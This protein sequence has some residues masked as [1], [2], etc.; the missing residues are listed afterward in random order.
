MK[1]NE[2]KPPADLNKKTQEDNIKPFIKEQ[3]NTYLDFCEDLDEFIQKTGESYN[4]QGL[5][6]KNFFYDL[7][8]VWKTNILE[9]YVWTNKAYE[10]KLKQIFGDTSPEPGLF[11]PAKDSEETIESYLKQRANRNIDEVEQRDVP[12]RQKKRIISD[13]LTA[14]IRRKYH[15]KT[16]SRPNDKRMF[17]YEDGVYREG[18]E[19]KIMQYLAEELQEDY[20]QNVRSLVTEKVQG[21]TFIFGKEEKEF[22]DNVDPNLLCVENGILNIEKRELKPHTHKKVF[23]KKI[24]VKYKEDAEY[25]AIEDFLLEVVKDKKDVETLQEMFGFCLYRKYEFKKAFIMLGDANNGKSTV[26]NILRKFLSED[27]ISAV[28]LQDLS[29]RFQKRPIV[30]MLANIVADIPSRAIDETADFKGLTGRDIMQYEVKGGGTFNF[31]NYAKLI[32]SA[33][34]LPRVKNATEAFFNRWV[35]IEFPYTFVNK[36]EYSELEEEDEDMSLYKVADNNVLESLFQRQTMSG[37]MNFALDGLRRLN[38]NKKFTRDD[39]VMSKWI[40]KSDSFKAFCL[41]HLEDASTEYIIQDHLEEVYQQYCSKRNHTYN[42]N[43][44][45]WYAELRTKYGASDKQKRFGE[46]R[47]K[48]WYGLKFRE[49]QKLSSGLLDENASFYKHKKTSIDFISQG[50]EDEEEVLSRPERLKQCFE[51][52]K[53]WAYEDLVDKGFSERFLEKMKTEGM[54]YEPKQGYLERI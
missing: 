4:L 38:D 12:V 2:G 34:E 33:N 49:E 22:L 29:K 21:E 17:Y 11:E 25:D 8:N 27:N 9:E 47:K 42:S 41:Q 52:E 18:G 39:N 6:R 36:E 5:N 51:E 23:F 1:N 14:R 10:E 3:V 54:L 37:L 32:Y 44:K 7:K 40:S 46:H 28:K 50:V 53:R 20:A 19:S 48:V 13:I 43:K 15:M 24:P 26:I 45:E 30:N 35:L 31:E 16:L